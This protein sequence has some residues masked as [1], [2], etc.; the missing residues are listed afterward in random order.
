MLIFPKIDDVSKKAN[1]STCEIAGLDSLKRVL[2]VVSGLK[3]I[4]L[5]TENIKILCVHFSYSFTLK[6]GIYSKKHIVSTSFLE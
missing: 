5:T 4:N 3:F 2:E 6:V 1:F